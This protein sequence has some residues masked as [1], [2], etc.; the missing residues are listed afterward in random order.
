M[1][2]R[3]PTPRVMTGIVSSGIIVHAA[4]R[5]PGPDE[6]FRRRF[7]LGC[8]KQVVSMAYS[9]VDLTR[10]TTEPLGM[11]PMYI[12]TQEFGCRRCRHG[13]GS[14]RLVWAEDTNEFWAG[15]G[16]TDSGIDVARGLW[17]EWDA[18]IEELVQVADLL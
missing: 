5:V 9:W 3:A 13:L 16:L 12:A 8:S 1:S 15:Y 11:H 14:G 4:A 17:R 7:V 6:L 18:T 2:R 10:R